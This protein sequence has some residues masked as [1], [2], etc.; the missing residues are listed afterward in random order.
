MHTV[1][2]KPTQET[3]GSRSNRPE[4]S[5]ASA[6]PRQVAAHSESTV[7][8]RGDDAPIPIGVSST[9]L[10]ERLWSSLLVPTLAVALMTWLRMALSD[11]LNE[12]TPFITYFL[13]VMIAAWYG[14]LGPA[15]VAIA[16]STLAAD[17]FFIPPI[18]TLQ[19]N[20]ASS[21]VG[22]TMFVIVSSAIALLAESQRNSRRR[23][24]TA[25][26]RLN[27]QQKELERQTH[28]RLQAEEAVRI[29][30]EELQTTIEELEVTEEEL[31]THNVELIK[32]RQT[33]ELERRRYLDLFE[34]APDGYI[35][36]DAKGV[37]REANRAASKM[38]GLPQ[39]ALAGEP[40]SG[41]VH[42]DCR[43]SLRAL[44]G[45]VRAEGRVD[46]C[47]LRLEPVDGKP[48][49]GLA[50]IA[51][52]PPR[53]GQEGGFHWLIRDVTDRKHAEQSL[54]ASEQRLQMALRAGRMGAWEWNIPRGRVTWSP[55]MEAIHGL[56]TGSFGGTLEAFQ[57][58]L[59]P[60][61]RDGVAAAIERALSD[62]A[63]Y[64]AEYRIIRPD[65]R[66]AWVEARGSVERDA[67]GKPVHMSGVC[68]DITEHKQT[69]ESLRDSEAQYRASFELAAVGKAQTDA[70]SG[71]FTRVNRK[72]CEITG[73]SEQELLEMT[74]SQITHPDDREP[75]FENWRR[76]VAG[77]INEHS[78]EKRY[79]R[80][81]GDIAWVNVTGTVVRD[82]EGRPVRGISVI[83]DVSARKKAEAE[84][85][86]H[87]ERLEELIAQRTH[88]L[89]DS[90]Q[91]L[92]LSER[93]AALGTLSAGLGHDM[94]NL[95]LPLRL[96]LDSMEAKA[97]TTENREDLEAIRKCAEYLQRLANGLRLF[98]L[99]PDANDGGADRTDLNEWW[100]DVF[101]FF[102]NALPRHV[103]LECRFNPELPPVRLA[104]PNLTQ[105]VFNLVQNA[106]DALKSRERG[107]VVVWAE[108]G[109]DIHSIR[110]GV[111]DDGPG[112]TREIRQR[113][114][115]PFFTTKT[116]AISTGLGLALVHGIVQKAGGIVE[117]HTELGRGST[118]VL[119]LPA[120]GDAD[121]DS[122]SRLQRPTAIISLHDERIRAYVI[123]VLQAMSFNVLSDG[124]PDHSD[125]ALWLTDPSEGILERAQAVMSGHAERRVMIFGKVSEHGPAL[126][127]GILEF[128]EAPKPAAIRQILRE[129]AVELTVPQSEEPLAGSPSIG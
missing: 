57:R 6:D 78:V 115:E 16:L 108:P 29:Q 114:L 106:G 45:A 35:V 12:S 62:G 46:H 118:F 18:H 84:L 86:M 30:N 122:A 66:I 119:T 64:R 103:T 126:N 100:P 123:S 23:A 55:G 39:A 77:A 10:S 17:Y 74:F 36:S 105:A 47:D 93:M 3:I 27:Q 69:E 94:G 1:A 32:T 2:K 40:L 26:V 37:I 28:A 4:L 61:D 88:E 50:T 121:V 41:F 33:I 43:E 72:L 85:D 22:L 63:E 124:Q 95:L 125:A 38:L 58:D 59:H 102:K 96:R 111:S 112:M 53:D 129:I 97:A 109:A 92:R 104:R 73:Y 11:A 120:G 127:N 91:K 9:R 110:I 5:M 70:E 99:D 113:C 128:G 81:N 24:E 51:G 82:A 49:D 67:G 20:G 42:V 83:Q 75:D 54:R 87:R 98:A 14:G 60:D 31:R 116:R 34:F 21:L 13:A 8:H 7:T 25:V 101:S 48:F 71:R 15:L 89:Q 65:G 80:K 19:I 79:L 117:I 90:H 68:I 76:M 56:E 44:L 107:E 52:I